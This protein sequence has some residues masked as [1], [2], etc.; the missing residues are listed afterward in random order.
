MKKLFSYTL[1]YIAFTFYAMGQENKDVNLI[2]RGDDIGSSHAA[3]LGCIKS[4][5]D[6]I[7]R[8]VEIMVPCSWF[9]EA[10][11]ML[12]E[13][14]GL[15]AGVHLVLTSEWENYKWSPVSCAPSLAD[16]DG[17]FYPTIWKRE[18]ATENTALRE[19][20]WKIEEIEQEFRAQIELAMKKIPQ[21]SH[22]TCHMGCSNWDPKVQEVF[23][24]LAKEYK[25]EIDPGKYNVKRTPRFEKGDTPEKTIENF[26]VMLENLE[27]GNYLFVEHPALDTPEMEAIGHEGYYNVGTDRNI[28]TMMFTSE[29]VKEVIKRKGINLISYADLPALTKD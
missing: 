7:M 1:L 11:K 6:G 16:E 20:N 29:I 4:Y 13:H 3:N 26:A 2:I 22:L 18:G 12:N 28:V 14:P 10:A 15:D 8:S 17:Y 24:K 23:N 25:L 27:P 9:P 19:A 5:R 21:V